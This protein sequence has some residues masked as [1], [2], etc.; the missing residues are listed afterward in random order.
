MKFYILA[1][2][3]IFLI[4]VQHNLRKTRRIHD[5]QEA[6]FW[7]REEQSNSV[8][9]K[10]LDNLDY[11]HIPM[12]TL[13]VHVL[14][15]NPQAAEY[16]RIIEEL[17]LVPIVNLTGFSNTDLKLEYGAANI[18]ILSEYDERYTRLVSTLQKWADLLYDEGYAE[19]AVTIMEFAVDTHTD[20]SRTYDLL[21]RIYLQT[22]RTDKIASL[23][24]VAE[25]LHS[26]NKKVILHHLEANR[27]ESLS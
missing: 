23:I 1:S 20:V 14:S 26:L 19:E 13:P 8:R 27:P 5:K 24:K 11:I 4:V 10:S 7:Q 6:S 16:I 22:G 21:S 12:E 17:S 3:I 18:T 25:S 2:F 9:R 15:D